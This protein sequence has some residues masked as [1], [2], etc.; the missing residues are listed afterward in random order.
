MVINLISKVNFS[1][2]SKCMINFAEFK[3]F[4]IWIFIGSLI[5]TA[6]VAV[7]T[8][9]IGEFTEI[10]ARVLLT[11]AMVI[12]HS[13]I[14]L[15]F[16]WDDS[17]RTTFEKLS[18]FINTIFLIIVA[19]FITSLF[20]IWKIIPVEVVSDTY[21]T[22]FLV[23]LAALHADILSKAAN[24]EKYMDIVIKV[25]Y[26]FIVLVVG[27]LLP[28]IYITNAHTVLGDMYYRILGAVAIIDGTLSILTIIFYKLF[29][30]KHPD[31]NPVQS[32]KPRRSGLS[33]LAWIV[34]IFFLLQFIG[35]FMFLLFNRF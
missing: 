26:V 30:R 17:R 15:S 23:G 34:I 13:L 14:S 16:I 33:M 20:S 31:L 18:F 21:Q 35:S 6:L 1:L 12:L 19:S 3:K 24:R 29:M 4:F 10:T 25:N 7:V 2:R 22:F 8:V 9:L 32:G 11:L 5:I 27:M 28:I